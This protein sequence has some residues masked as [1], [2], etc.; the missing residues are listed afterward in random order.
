[1]TSSSTSPSP[2]L[3]SSLPFPRGKAAAVHFPSLCALSLSLLFHH[4]FFARNY[5]GGAGNFSEA[6]NELRR[7]FS[8][9]F[10]P[11]SSLDAPLRCTTAV[12]ARTAARVQN[13]RRR[14]AHIRRQ[15][16]SGGGYNWL[17]AKYLLLQPLRVRIGLRQAG[18]K[19]SRP[20]WLLQRTLNSSTS[21]ARSPG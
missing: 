3:R 12:R 10:L 18:L 6:V 2:F 21:T 20:P 4:D 8:S 16:C 9:S 5:G 7:P 1:M 19:R 14:D 13:R 15:P 11:P 17:A